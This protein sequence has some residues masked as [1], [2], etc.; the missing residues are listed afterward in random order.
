MTKYL[1]AIAG[2]LIGDERSRQIG[3]NDGHNGTAW[4]CPAGAD[5]L[6]YSLGYYDGAQAC[7]GGDERAQTEGLQ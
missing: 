1:Q 4:C 3:W 7:C 6:A 2:A 5:V